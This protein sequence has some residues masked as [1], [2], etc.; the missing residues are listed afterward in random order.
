ME[1]SDMDVDV[2]KRKALW[3]LDNLCSHAFVLIERPSMPFLLLFQ[4]TTR[5]P[6][7]SPMVL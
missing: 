7:L 6:L 2:E 4:L 5:V 1:T 3:S